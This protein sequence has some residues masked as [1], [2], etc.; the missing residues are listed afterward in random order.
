MRQLRDVD[1]SYAPR[2]RAR[3]GVSP[4]LALRQVPETAGLRAFLT[5][6]DGTLIATNALHTAA[7]CDAFRAYGYPVHPSV[8]APMIGMGADKIVSLV[9]RHLTAM[10]GTGKAIAED[11]Q[12]RFLNGYLNE[13]VPTPGARDLLVALRGLGIK[14]YVAT[15]AQS[16]ERRAL[17]E[18]AGVNDLVELPP[19]APQSSKPDPDVVCAALE[20]AAVPPAHARML[21]DTPYDIVA[22]ARAG[23]ATVALRCG[24]WDDRSLAAAAAIYDDPGEALAFIGEW[25]GAQGA[26][27]SAAR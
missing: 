2:G 7:W 12:R 17:L 21:G 23:V 15:S 27:T 4:R 13:A 24:G 6:I 14:I 20:Q 1:E 16:E 9:A 11:R 3:I 26:E 25:G 22:A 19:T 18:R 8:I 5:D 10:E